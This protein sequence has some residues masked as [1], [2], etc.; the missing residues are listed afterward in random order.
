VPAGL[1]GGD[2]PAAVTAQD[3]LPAL[4]PAPGHEAPRRPARRPAA[5]AT[6]LIVAAAAAVV[7]YDAAYGPPVPPVP[8]S[9]RAF[10]RPAGVTA[11]LPPWLPRWQQRVETVGRGETLVDALARAGVDR[12]AAARLVREAGPLARPYAARPVRAGSAVYVR[13]LGEDSLPA[14]VT[15]RPAA[16][17]VVRL[18][19]LR[20]AWRAAEERL[21]WRTDTVG[22]TTAVQSTLFAAVHGALATH[23]PRDERSEIVYKLGDIFEY[24]VDVGEEVGRGDSV[25]LVV[26]RRVDP[27]GTPHDA[28]ILAASL[29]A[30]GRRVEAFRFRSGS[31]SADYFDG[32]GKSL[33]AAFLRAPLEFRRV[34][35]NFGMRH[36]PILGIWRMHAGTDYSASSG[37]PVRTVGDGTVIFAGRKGGYGNVLEVRHRNGYISRYGHLRGFAPGVR[38]GASVAMGRTIGYVG[39]T[40]LATAPHLHFELLVGG[41]QRDPRATLRKSDADLLPRGERG[42]LAALRSRLLG[43]FAG[44]PAGATHVALGE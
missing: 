31:T 4:H 18:T 28:K 42:A 1:S 7:A 5:A 14:E 41:A 23:L 44:R 39:A 13:A 38:R 17:R 37:T 22:A 30:G 8:R 35:S 16:D 21:A 27:E 40:G 33:R 34:S 9:V 29:T 12:D 36:H 3:Q 11:E 6:T 24:R 19:Y 25:R 26:E 15:F 32:A 43:R 20:G 10:A 2:N